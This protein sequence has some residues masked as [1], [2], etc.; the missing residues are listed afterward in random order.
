[1]FCGVRACGRGARA[2]EKTRHRHLA[3]VALA[4]ALAPSAASAPTD[5]RAHRMTDMSTAS[6]SC[7]GPWRE[8]ISSSSSLR[9]G[10]AAREVAQ[11]WWVGA[12]ERA[13]ARH[14]A[15][16]ASGRPRDM[17]RRAAAE[18]AVR[19]GVRAGS[20]ARRGSSQCSRGALTGYTFAAARPCRPPRPPPRPPWQL[21]AARGRMCAG[22][23]RE[24]CLPLGRGCFFASWIR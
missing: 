3:P 7:R 9:E 14:S 20:E 17:P 1:M 22:V 15:T 4:S 18:G 8:L 19:C 11:G 23:G 21:P 2:E 5:R 6:G 10:H 24:L 16:L 13:R 12:S